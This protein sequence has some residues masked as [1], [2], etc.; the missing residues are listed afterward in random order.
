[1]IVPLKIFGSVIVPS[2]ATEKPSSLASPQA[3]VPSEAVGVVELI[4]KGLRAF[5]IVLIALYI[6]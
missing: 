4:K 2:L 5:M 6:F 3:N 1:M